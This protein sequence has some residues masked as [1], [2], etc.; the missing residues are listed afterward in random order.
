MFPLSRLIQRVECKFI[1]EVVPGNNGKGIE[2]YYRKVKEACIIGQVAIQATEALFHWGTLGDRNVLPMGP[3]YNS[4]S[5]P[6]RGLLLLDTS[7]QALLAYPHIW[8][9]RK[10]S[11][12]IPGAYSLKPS[13]CTAKSESEAI[14]FGD[15]Q[16][17]AEPRLMRAIYRKCNI[18]GGKFTFILS[19]PCPS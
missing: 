7:S 17:Q 12:R 5:I 8:T 6:G 14:W 18:S 9:G 4:L 15:W 13:A 19:S 3:L 11:D 16:C 10:P 1:W 2:K